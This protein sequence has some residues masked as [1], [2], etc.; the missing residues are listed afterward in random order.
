MARAD[1]LC[2]KL[3]R[4]QISICSSNATPLFRSGMNYLC[5]MVFLTS[6]LFQ[7]RLLFN[8]GASKNTLGDLCLLLPC[9]AYGNG[10]MPRSFKNPRS[11]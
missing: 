7:F 9:G 2:A 8:G 5:F 4:N 6:S 11:L 10:G 3:Q 1:V